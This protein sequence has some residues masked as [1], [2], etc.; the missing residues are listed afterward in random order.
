MIL[1]VASLAAQDKGGTF[2]HAVSSIFFVDTEDEK[3]ARQLAERAAYEQA[4]TIWNGK[5]F[6]GHSVA[7]AKVHIKEEVE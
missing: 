2:Y 6:F 1:Y 3:R 4:Y 7:L 5:Q